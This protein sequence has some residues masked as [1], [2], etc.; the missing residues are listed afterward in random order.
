MSE[1]RLGDLVKIM[2]P[3]LKKNRDGYLIS[4]KEEIDVVGMQATDQEI[5]FWLI[6]SFPA[7]TLPALLRRLLLLMME[8]SE[9][10]PGER[11]R[12][13]TSINGK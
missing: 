10:E 11:R 5:Y 3:I 9:S 8:I 6:L 13:L 12:G 7:A 4:A 1:N 2:A